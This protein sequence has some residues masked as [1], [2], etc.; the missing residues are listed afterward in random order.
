VTAPRPDRG[1]GF[2]FPIAVPLVVQP[3][4]LVAMVAF[5]AQGWIYVL[6][7]IYMGVVGFFLWKALSR[8]QFAKA[9][10]GAPTLTLG[11]WRFQ[12]LFFFVI[13]P[14][15]FWVFFGLLPLLRYRG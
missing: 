5:R 1:I 6:H 13:L 11:T 15:L 3:A 10:A 12:W 14:M 2:S 4:L 8:A 9:Q 7:V